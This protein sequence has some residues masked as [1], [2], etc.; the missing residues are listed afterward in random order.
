MRKYLLFLLI[1]IIG[2]AQ[3]QS[4]PDTIIAH[5]SKVYPCRITQINSDGFQLVYGANQQTRFSIRIA[6][7]II[8]EKIGKIYDR[9]DGFLK[10]LGPVQDYIKERNGIYS[11]LMRLDSIAAI[12][13]LVVP[14]GEEEGFPFLDRVGTN[15]SFGFFYSPLIQGKRV[16]YIY[17]Y[18]LRDDFIITDEF[19]T[20]VESQFSTALVNKF[21]LT[22]N[23]AY[24]A[25][26]TKT[27]SEYHQTDFDPIGQSDSGLEKLNSLKI[28]TIETGLKYYFTDFAPRKTSIYLSAGIGKKI[29]FS[30]NEGK[31]LFK[32][33]PV[34]EETKTTDNFDQYLEELNSP[35]LLQLGFGA[36]YFFNM[37]LSAHSS[38]RFYY[39]SISAK[40]KQTELGQYSETEITRKYEFDEINTRIGFGLNFYF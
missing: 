39:S 19:S 30:E 13:E 11:E 37:S 2:F 8:I 15:S 3:K 32:D 5:Q 18:N 4:Y 35:F 17:N 16:T 40:F 36:E 6:K 28:F 34:E 24:N 9:E 12:P 27:R 20:I 7:K 29:A 26:T 22:L 31:E 33:D 21:Y 10:E 23:V 1:P 25:A 14:K 38:I